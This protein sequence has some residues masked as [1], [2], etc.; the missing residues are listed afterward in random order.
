MLWLQSYNPSENI[1]QASCNA[2]YPIIW[3]RAADRLEFWRCG[4]QPERDNTSTSIRNNSRL[5][6]TI[7][8]FSTTRTCLSGDS[9]RVL[10]HAWPKT[11]RGQNWHPQEEAIQHFYWQASI[12]KL[13]GVTDSI[14][15]SAWTKNCANTLT[16]QDP[17]IAAM[18]L[19]ACVVFGQSLITIWNVSLPPCAK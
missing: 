13:N 10:Q 1:P 14:S 5:Q 11:D 6:A 3:S 18:P 19:K 16:C 4:Q 8:L 15:L 12:R 7:H 9:W 17:S 2:T